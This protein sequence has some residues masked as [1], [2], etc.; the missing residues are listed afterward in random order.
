LYRAV[1]LLCGVGGSVSGRPIILYPTIEL[2]FP[3]D[4]A[5]LLGFDLIDRLPPDPVEFILDRAASR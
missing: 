2:P 3:L 5:G 1:S 4:G